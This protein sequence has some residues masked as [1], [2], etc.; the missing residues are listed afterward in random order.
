MFSRAGAEARVIVTTNVRDVFRVLWKAA[1]AGEPQAGVVLTSDRGLPR[2]AAGLDALEAALEA[3]LA[4]Y[5]DEWAL[6]NRVVRIGPYP[7]GSQP[8]RV[9]G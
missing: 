9:D 1:D 2:H 7:L 6:A 4:A 5:P 8:A 3:A